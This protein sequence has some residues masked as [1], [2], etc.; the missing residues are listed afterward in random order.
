MFGQAHRQL[1]FFRPQ[2]LRTTPGAQ[3]WHVRYIGPEGIAMEGIDAGGL[4]RDS[5]TTFCQELQ[6]PAVPLFLPCPNSKSEIGENKEKYIPNPNCTSSLHLSMYAFVG[7]LMGV[8]IR[9]R[10]T[11]DLDLSNI[12]WKPL[13][14]QELVRSDIEAIDSMSFSM[15]DM[16]QSRSPPGAGASEP[17]SYDEDE[18][19]SETLTFSI[20]SSDG[21]SVE[22]KQGGSEIKVTWKNRSEFLKLYKEYRIQE[23]TKQVNASKQGL[24]TIVPVQLLPLFTPKQLELMVTLIILL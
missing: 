24:A 20:P 13:V 15:M 19:L 23:Y 6:S 8:A 18:V 21:R 1:H 4:F 10:H 9:G 22:L 7:K 11:L 12:V 2:G 3:T 16:V 5:M 14:G 17:G